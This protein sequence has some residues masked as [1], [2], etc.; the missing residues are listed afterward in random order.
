MSFDAPFLGPAQLVEELLWLCGQPQKSVSQNLLCRIE[1]GAVGRS[2]ARVATQSLDAIL[3]V[4][5]LFWWK[6]RPGPA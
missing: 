5:G 3:K 1:V 2:N 4:P 6:R